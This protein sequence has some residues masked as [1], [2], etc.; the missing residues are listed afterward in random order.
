MEVG[1]EVNYIPI[2]TL[3]T[4]RKTPTLRWAAMRTILMFH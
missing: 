1:G 4:I 3:V 2:T